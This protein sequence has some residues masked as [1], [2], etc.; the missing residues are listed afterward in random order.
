MMNKRAG[1]ISITTG[2]LIFA[3]GWITRD[4]IASREE[5][6]RSAD[7]AE[8][9]QE[10]LYDRPEIP[11]KRIEDQVMTERRTV[12]RP[13]NEMDR[14]GERIRMVRWFESFSLDDVDAARLVWESGFDR[15]SP[16]RYEFLGLLIDRWAALDPVAALE[17]VVGLEKPRDRSRGVGALVPRW[18]KQSPDAVTEWAGLMGFFDGGREKELSTV[19]WRAWIN[20]DPDGAA[21]QLSQMADLGL[22]SSHLGS[23]ITGWRDRDGNLHQ[24]EAWTLTLPEGPIRKG[25]LEQLIVAK[26]RFEADDLRSWLLE[27]LPQLTAPDR[28]VVAHQ[29]MSMLIYKNHEDIA[30][31]VDWALDHQLTSIDRPEFVDTLVFWTQV[32]NGHQVAYAKTLFTEQGRSMDELALAVSAKLE[33]QASPPRKLEWIQAVED[34]ELRSQALQDVLDPWFKKTP[35]SA[36]KWIQANKVPPEIEARYLD[37]VDER[38]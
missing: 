9:T 35:E 13:L 6:P 34:V 17:F 21:R 11:E 8:T 30:S 1:F 27:R 32:K 12:Y 7:L 4:F 36:L 38:P 31:T 23:L 2:V 37:L 28:D 10:E 5:E 15:N 18:L 26:G 3:A 19:F 14:L 20:H 33:D 24:A 25:A 22:P 29:G 16:L